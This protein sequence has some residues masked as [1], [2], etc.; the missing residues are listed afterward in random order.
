MTPTC[1][2]HPMSRLVVL[3]LSCLAMTFVLVATTEW[4]SRRGSPALAPPRTPSDPCTHLRQSML[5]WHDESDDESDRR[6]MATLWKHDLKT[7]C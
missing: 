1:L 7:L 2:T 4:P 5:A 6:R 3:L